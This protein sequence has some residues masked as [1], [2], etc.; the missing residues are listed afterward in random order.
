MRTLLGAALWLAAA[1]SLAA[2]GV[3]IVQQR[4]PKR[5]DSD[6]NLTVAHQLAQA[7][8]DDGRAAPIVW[9]MTDPLFRA[10]VEDGLIRRPKENPSLEEAFD[11]ADRMKVEY[12]L[13]VVAL[14]DRDE[15]EGSVVLYRKRKEAWR[16]AHKAG[17]S[18]GGRFDPFSTAATLARTWMERL[19]AGPW[20]GLPPR[21]GPRNT[22][23]AP[24]KTDPT[25]EAKPPVLRPADNSELLPKLAELMR[26]NDVPQVVAL[27]RDAIDA[28]PLDLG[29]RRLFIDTM[30]AMGQTRLAADEARRSA[31]LFPEAV[32]LRLLASRAYA[33]LGDEAASQEQLKEAVARDPNGPA[34][35]Q[36][37]GERA[38]LDLQPEAALQHLLKATELGATSEALFRRALAYAL[39]GDRRRFEED[40][41]A[42]RDAASEPVVAQSRYSLAVRLADRLVTRASQDGAAALQAARVGRTGREFQDRMASLRRWCEALALALRSTPAPSVATRA[43]EQR[44]LASNL[45][46]QF[47]GQLQDAASRNDAD[48]LDEATLTLAQAARVWDAAKGAGSGPAG[49][50]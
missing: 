15:A 45:L 12:V 16:D 27:L 13:V 9:S 30:L 22:E 14:R 37:L 29:R 40:S 11:A 46:M 20:R 23:A 42:A 31:D 8:D 43:H 7:I 48:L 50:P 28:Q 38:L 17:V 32:E 33:E 18:A 6:F 25:V 5:Y 26:Q 1:A 10:A 21:V 24:T 2:P 19:A 44:L 3:L 39:A 41:S 4:A 49:K 34:T 35:R 47:V 36:A